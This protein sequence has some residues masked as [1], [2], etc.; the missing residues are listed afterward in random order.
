MEFH[1]VHRNSA[2]TDPTWEGRRGTGHP[3]QRPIAQDLRGPLRI[4]GAAR[5]PFIGRLTAD[6]LILPPPAGCRQ[7]VAGGCQSFSMRDFRGVAPQGRNPA[8]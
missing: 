7:R 1:L 8:R 3:Y 4:A 2:K 5:P 6:I